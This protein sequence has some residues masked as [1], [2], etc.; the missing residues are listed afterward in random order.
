MKHLLVIITLLATQIT[1]A[2]DSKP[3]LIKP[4]T[5]IAAP[6]F[7]QPL[8]ADW[9][10]AQ[11]TWQPQQGILTA[12]EVPAEKHSAVL[13]HL[14]KLQSACITCEFRLDGAKAFL[15]G[16]DGQRHVGRVVITP[17][18]MS[19]AEDSKAPSH[20]IATLPMAVKSG[21]WHQ[22]RVEWSGDRMAARLD[23]KE[24]QAQHPYLATPKERWWF[25]VGKAD[26]KIRNLTVQSDSSLR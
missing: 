24:L 7:K 12:A 10:I 14:V 4:T 21:E 3:L 25:A 26:A 11:G 8:G 15:I 13:W 20:V 19:I 2:D 18:G 9:K 1:W 22:L 23:G 16:C 5:T 6:D 17:T